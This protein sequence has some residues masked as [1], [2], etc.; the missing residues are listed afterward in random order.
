[1]SYCRVWLYYKAHT[2]LFQD[3]V[4]HVVKTE[5]LSAV[6]TP[7][8]NPPSTLP[9]SA[10]DDTPSANNHSF[11]PA[12][13]MITTRQSRPR[14]TKVSESTKKRKHTVKSLAVCDPEDTSEEDSNPNFDGDGLLSGDTM[15][16]DA[17][18]PPKRPRVSRIVT[19]SSIA[20]PCPW[21]KN[22]R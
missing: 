7:G 3:R 6:H 18:M 11:T 22:G 17:P 2:C 21:C 5:V 19:R 16:D 10:I 4:L 13:P 8:V 9:N 14:P 20:T 15:S 12:G 1:M